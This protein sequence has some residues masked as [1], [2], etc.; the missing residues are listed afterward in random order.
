MLSILNGQKDIRI[1]HAISNETNEPNESERV[2]IYRTNDCVWALEARPRCSLTCFAYTNREY[3]NL[4]I[5]DL[6]LPLEMNPHITQIY[7]GSLDVCNRQ[8]F[9]KFNGHKQTPFGCP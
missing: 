2:N 4:S 3:T 8:V 7:L 1:L 6:R 9:K 5:R